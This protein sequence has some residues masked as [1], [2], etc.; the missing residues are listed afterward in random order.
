MKRLPH[1]VEVSMIH[2]FR[3]ESWNVKTHKME[4]LCKPVTWAQRCNVSISLQ[5]CAPNMSMILKNW[6]K[7][8]GGSVS[9]PPFLFSSNAQKGE[10]WTPSCYLRLFLKNCSIWNH[11]TVGTFYEDR[12]SDLLLMFIWKLVGCVPHLS[13]VSLPGMHFLCV[14]FSSL[15]PSS[16]KLNCSD[17]CQQWDSNPRPKTSTWN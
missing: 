8:L 4:P 12:I 15:S 2:M 7:F 17:V 3:V 16:K 11:F 9:F 5:R 1:E 13:E 14:T 10:Q 6:L